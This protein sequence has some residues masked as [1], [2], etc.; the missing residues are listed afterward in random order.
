MMVLGSSMEQWERPRFL[1]M[2]MDL[3]MDRT[4]RTVMA[5]PVMVLRSRAIS[6]SILEAAL[7]RIYSR[8]SSVHLWVFSPF[9]VAM[10]GSC[11]V[12]PDDRVVGSGVV[13]DVG[14]VVPASTE[15]RGRCD[16]RSISCPRIKIHRRAR[17]RRG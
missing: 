16:E 9:L 4:L 17:K 6:S 11:G 12:V 2:P 10:V 1:R 13:R 7:T 15:S 5:S 14:T 3:R 8:S